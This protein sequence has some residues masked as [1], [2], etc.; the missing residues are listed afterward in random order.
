MTAS[1]GTK[2]YEEI[3]D[4]LKKTNYAHQV[5]EDSEEEDKREGENV[6]VLNDSDE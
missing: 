3:M 2:E 4:R 5:E 6:N 1:K